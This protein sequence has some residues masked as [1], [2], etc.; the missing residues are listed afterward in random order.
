MAEDTAGGGGSA[1]TDTDDWSWGNEEVATWGAEDDAETPV[2]APPSP[3]TPEGA[4]QAFH[5]QAPASRPRA[6]PAP[7]NPP[8]CRPSKSPK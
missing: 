5:A 8:S 6:P 4:V 7:T 3:S 2:L 1:D